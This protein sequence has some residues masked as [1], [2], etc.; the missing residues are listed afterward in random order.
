[1]QEETVIF[2]I[3]SFVIAGGV[4][5][6]VNAMKYR[7]KVMEM[8]HRERLAMIE[9]GLKPTGPPLSHLGLDRPKARKSRMLSGGIVIVGFGLALAT[10]IGFASR[11]P[12]IAVGVGGAVAILG[13]AFIVT[14][15]V[16]Q[17][18]RKEPEPEWPST[19]RPDQTPPPPPSFPG[20]DSGV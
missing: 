14:A 16:T 12:E 15:Y 2:W 11:E 4:F 7:A 20:S 3:F 10:V 17:N 5:V 1:M 8:A 18:D 6:I 13:A 19:H 9:R